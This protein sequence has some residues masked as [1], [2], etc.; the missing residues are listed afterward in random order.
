MFTR[1]VFAYVALAERGAEV[2][3]VVGPEAV[4]ARIAEVFD[5]EA[6]GHFVLG[7]SRFFEVALGDESF[8]PSGEDGGGVGAREVAEFS[9]LALDLCAFL[10]CIALG[11]ELAGLFEL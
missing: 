10:F 5:Q 2:G 1:S 3:G 8:E 7:D 6:G 9:E 11:E 4:D